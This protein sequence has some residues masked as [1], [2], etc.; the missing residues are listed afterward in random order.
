VAANLCVF[1]AW[2]YTFWNWLPSYRFMAFIGIV[3]VTAAGVIWLKIAPF[4]KKPRERSDSESSPPS[5]GSTRPM[6]RRRLTVFDVVQSQ[7]V[8]N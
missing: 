7:K 1:L 3:Q 4:V 2:V 5:G 8:S 6:L